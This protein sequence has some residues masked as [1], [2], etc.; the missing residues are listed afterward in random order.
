MCS[1]RLEWRADCL[2]DGKAGNVWT[3]FEPEAVKTWVQETEEA[4]GWF[5]SRFDLWH[6]G[7]GLALCCHFEAWTDSAEEGVAAVYSVKPQSDDGTDEEGL[8]PNLLFG[9]AY[10][11]EVPPGLILTC[12]LSVDLEDR[13]FEAGFTTLAGNQVLRAREPLPP[14]LC[15]EHVWS[16]GVDRLLEN[17]LLRSRNQELQILL[18]SHVVELPL[19]AVLWYEPARSD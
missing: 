5:V 12:A 2:G 7:R 11:K 16:L 3:L 18:E 10:V 13:S 19:E 15:V 6:D 8:V 9:R 17:G 14:V 4:P 1:R